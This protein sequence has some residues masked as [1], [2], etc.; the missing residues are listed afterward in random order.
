MAQKKTNR[1]LIA[2][3]KKAFHNIVIQEKFE[4]GIVLVGCEV[5]SIRE[6]M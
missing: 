1:T 3:N 4:C 5:K 6:K 2:S